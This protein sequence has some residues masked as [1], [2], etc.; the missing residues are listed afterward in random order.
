MRKGSHRSGS[1]SVKQEPRLGFSAWRGVGSRS[2][3]PQR[4][5]GSASSIPPSKKDDEPKN[6]DEY[7]H[8]RQ[9]GLNRAHGRLG[10]GGA[11]LL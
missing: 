3:L 4:L 5:L 6:V 2:L 7:E 8:A 10:G 1:S 9:H 11:A